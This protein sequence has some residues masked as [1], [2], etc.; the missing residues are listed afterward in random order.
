MRVDE[1][2]YLNYTSWTADRK[3]ARRWRTEASR[4]IP[5]RNGSSSR[6][7]LR[8]HH[9]GNMAGIF[10]ASAGSDGRCTRLRN[11]SKQ[12]I[13]RI[14]SLYPT[15][16]NLFSAQSDPALHPNAVKP[17]TGA[18]PRCGI[19]SIILRLSSRYHSCTRRRILAAVLP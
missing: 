15:S 8:S 10:F 9:H 13:G 14:G 16:L 2:L 19:C 1:R 11:N 17:G 7:I 4:W 3:I 18:T 5:S 6:K 12:G